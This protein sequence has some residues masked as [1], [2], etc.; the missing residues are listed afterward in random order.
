MTA[1]P[2]SSIP[3][4]YGETPWKV[5]D[6]SIVTDKGKMVLYCV[7]QYAVV[8]RIVREHN[9]LVEAKAALEAL[10]VNGW[11]KDCHDK[12]SERTCGCYAV[13]AVLVKMEG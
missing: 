1:T 3:D 7:T 11:F 6:S 9:Y 8:A 10:V 5:K 2:R 4:M 13:K 12:Q